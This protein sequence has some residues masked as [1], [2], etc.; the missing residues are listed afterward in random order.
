MWTQSP[1]VC[2]NQFEPYQAKELR[3]KE[4]ECEVKKVKEC[5]EDVE[6]KKRQWKKCSNIVR[7]RDWKPLLLREGSQGKNYSPT[8]IMEFHF[9]WLFF[10]T[11]SKWWEERLVLAMISILPQEMF[12]VL[13]NTY[14]TVLS[15][16]CTRK[17]PWS[18]WWKSH[19]AYKQ[20]RGVVPLPALCDTLCVSF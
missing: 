15:E 3:S 5:K 11:F 14:R 7:K 16:K 1:S 2:C 8:A 6:E 12:K 20:E 9:A 19:F 18:M 10:S 13:I 4:F 17:L